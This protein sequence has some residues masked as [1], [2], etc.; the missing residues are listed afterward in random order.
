[1]DG[2][3]KFLFYDGVALL[4]G[5]PQI[6][7]TVRA[8]LSGRKFFSLWC[9]RFALFFLLLIAQIYTDVG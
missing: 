6:T 8:L 9:G 2:F 3:W 7:S 5:L 1:V 4:G